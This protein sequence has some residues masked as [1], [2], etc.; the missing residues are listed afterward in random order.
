[1][2]IIFLSGAEG[3]SWSLAIDVS[4]LFAFSGESHQQKGFALGS[5]PL[6]PRK[7]SPCRFSSFARHKTWTI[8]N[9]T[10]GGIFIVYILNLGRKDSNLRDGWTKTSCLTTWR[11]P[12]TCLLYYN[13]ISK[14]TKWLIFSNCSYCIIPKIILCTTLCQHILIF[15]NQILLNCTM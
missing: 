5:L 2:R 9:T 7:A 8:K 15:Q 10:Q 14:F 12:I 4:T 11:R 6:E 3:L 1:M 13:M